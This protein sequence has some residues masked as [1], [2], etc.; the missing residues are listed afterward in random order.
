MIYGCGVSNGDYTAAGVDGE[1]S[2]ACLGGDGIGHRVG[3]A[4]GVDAEAV[5]SADAPLATFSASVLSSLS[6]SDGA[7]TLNSSTSV[8]VTETVCVATFPPASVAVT[9]TT[10]GLA[11]QV[12]DS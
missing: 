10:H 7:V 1:G 12:S 2:G 6:V 3:G 5:I 11:V 9:T 4:I 8:I